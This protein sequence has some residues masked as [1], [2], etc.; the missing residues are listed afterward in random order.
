MTTKT[1]KATVVQHQGFQQSSIAKIAKGFNGMKYTVHI[2][3][4][5]KIKNNALL[6]EGGLQG[7]LH[8]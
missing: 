2:L 3:Q 8:E 1:Q 6:L 7:G 4:M 5:Q